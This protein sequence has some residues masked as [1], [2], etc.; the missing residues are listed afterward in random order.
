MEQVLTE[1]PEEC[2]SFW[3][4][5]AMSSAA[6]S[7]VRTTEFLR[8]NFR[9]R[10]LMGVSPSVKDEEYCSSS[11]GCSGIMKSVFLV[12]RNLTMMLQECLLDIVL[13]NSFRIDVSISG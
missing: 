11:S 4:D 7:V 6:S 12:D 13:G 8:M 3:I 10:G 5:S 1:L 2:A 9:V